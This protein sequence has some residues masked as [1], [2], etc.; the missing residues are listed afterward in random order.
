MDRHCYNARRQGMIIDFMTLALDFM[1]SNWHWTSWITLVWMVLLLTI[2][3]VG[4]GV[5]LLA[6]LDWSLMLV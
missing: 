4:I 2:L 5:L 6:L 3:D 1:G